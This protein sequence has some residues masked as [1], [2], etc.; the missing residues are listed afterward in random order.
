MRKR[1]V[2][3][4]TAFLLLVGLLAGCAGQPSPKAD[5]PKADATAQLG[6]T[7]ELKAP[8]ERFSQPQASPAAQSAAAGPSPASGLRVEAPA[9]PPQRLEP[10]GRI[11]YAW[12]TGLSPAWL[13]PQENGLVI[14]P[15]MTQY[16]LHDAVV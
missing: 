1:P 5:A 12:S 9:P 2:W 4:L 10:K 8:G 14:S 13:D 11:V 3:H 15:Y 7:V 6:P 16:A